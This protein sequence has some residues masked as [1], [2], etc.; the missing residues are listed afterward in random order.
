MWSPEEREQ[1]L[2]CE[3]QL[4]V[5]FGFFPVSVAGVSSEVTA[6]P[7][8][9]CRHIRKNITKKTENDVPKRGEAGGGRPAAGGRR[10]DL[11]LV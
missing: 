1:V 3:T 2:R 8:T 10:H 11:W 4:V 9:L 5:R 6:L 7:S